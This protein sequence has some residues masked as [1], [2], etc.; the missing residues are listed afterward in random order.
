MK[1]FLAVALQEG[2]HDRAGGELLLQVQEVEPAPLLHLH[3]GGGA[4]AAATKERPYVAL[5]VAVQEKS[6]LD[7]ILV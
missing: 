3:G 5:R 6:F 1:I 4:A 7:F 2:F